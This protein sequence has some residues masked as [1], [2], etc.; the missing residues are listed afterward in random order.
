MRTIPVCELWEDLD[1]YPRVSVD[2]DNVSNLESALRAGAT[3]PPIVIEK[4]CNRIVDGVHRCRAYSAVFGEEHPV[5]VVEKV[6]ANDAEFFLDAVRYNATHGAGLIHDDRRHIAAVCDRLSVSADAVAGALSTTVDR[7]GSLRAVRAP[8][9]LQPSAVPAIKPKSEIDRRIA[10]SE[11]HI[12]RARASE[13]SKMGHATRAANL[14]ERIDDDHA[15]DFEGC[16]N[17]L[18]TLLEKK[19]WDSTNHGLK[20]KCARLHLLLEQVFA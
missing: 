17:Q 18:I 3:L 19:G 13:V 20:R 16:V 1:L 6:Y 11:R 14:L 7:L 9:L 8:L 12:D 15:V 4:E 10:R 2:D 5:S